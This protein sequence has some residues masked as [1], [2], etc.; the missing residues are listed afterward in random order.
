MA[1]YQITFARTARKELESLSAALVERMIKKIDG[2]AME[3][4]PRGCRKLSGEENLWRIREGDY[5]I[6]YA[7]FDRERVVDIVRIRHRRDVYR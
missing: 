5:R 3:P 7:V 4:R 1:D 6:V 2:L